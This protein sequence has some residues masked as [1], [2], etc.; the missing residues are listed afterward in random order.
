MLLGVATPAEA[1]AGFASK[2]WL[3]VLAIYGVAAA[4]AR[5]GVLLRLGLLLV[6][7]LP[8]SLAAQAVTLMVTGVALTP[9]LPSGTGRVSLLAPIAVAVAETLRLPERS[10]A[11]ATIGLGA[12]LGAAPM[13][14][15]FLTGSSTCLL[16]WGLLPD[17]SRARFTWMR[18]LVATAP[19][20]LALCAGGLALLFLL[21]R[22]GRLA[23][24]SRERIGLQAAVLGPPSPR[25]LGM[26][27]ILFLTVAGFIAAPWLGVEL[28][29]VALL[30]LLAAAAI[31]SF[32]ARAFQ[33]LDWSFLVFFG[34]V[35][36]AGRLAVTLGLDRAASAAITAALGESI[37]GAT[38][39]VVVV[40]A[41]SVVVRLVLDQ[42][43]T[44]ILMSVTLV[45]VATRLGL[46]PWLVTIALLATSAAWILPAQ[47]SA[48]LVA[49]SATEGRL[50]THAQAQRLALAYT[51]LTLLG[52]A[53]SVPYWRALGLV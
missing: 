35:L 29:L 27:A 41:L 47:T 7:R 16:A 8:P 22:A 25:E 53:L 6:R 1:L 44:V 50:F 30:A 9:L 43:L 49:Q 45:P 28:T 20:G 13:M 3:F 11:S 38:V 19:L 21:F 5:S 10:P 17:A 51:L 18:W 33:S 36:G 52:L 2:E 23:T 14:F 24:P 15:L 32:D 26:A 4:T 31:G 39:F 12:W 34:V 42:D 37:P 48:Y 46:E 40:A